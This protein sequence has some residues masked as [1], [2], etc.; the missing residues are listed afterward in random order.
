ML[1]NKLL[2]IFAEKQIKACKVS[3][4][5]GIAESTISNL[6]NNKTDVKLSTLVKLCNFLGVNLSDLI[7]FTPEK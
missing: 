6:A 7:E 2:I 4:E 1:K 5:T 3:K